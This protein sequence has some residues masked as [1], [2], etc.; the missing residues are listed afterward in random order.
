LASNQ[1]RA[2]RLR[3]VIQSPLI[4]NQNG[5]A[6]FERLFQFFEARRDFLLSLP[7]CRRRSFI[8]IPFF[9]KCAA[10]ASRDG[11]WIIATLQIEPVA[12]AKLGQ[13]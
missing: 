8:I 7:I 4:A 12:D 10:A 3:L 9:A 2:L 5:D 13:S 11:S 1:A 6:K